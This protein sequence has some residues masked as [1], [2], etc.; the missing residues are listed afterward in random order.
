LTQF[1]IWFM[2]V[3]TGDLGFTSAQVAT[4]RAEGVV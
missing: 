4:L 1:G 2:G 3:L